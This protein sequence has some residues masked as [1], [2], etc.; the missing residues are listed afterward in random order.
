MTS[1]LAQKFEIPDWT[2]VRQV[3]ASHAIDDL[4]IN[5]Y[6][7]KTF[8]I[9]SC[10]PGIAKQLE[11]TVTQYLGTQAELIDC[12]IFENK[13]WQ[14]AKI[15][16]DGYEPS[17]TNSTEVALNLPLLNP[18]GAFMMWYG[19]EY[20]LIRNVNKE[21][22]VEYLEVAWLSMPKELYR[23]EILCPTLVKVDIPHRVTNLKATPRVMLSARFSP[24]L[25]FSDAETTTTSTS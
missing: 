25:K 22:G 12:L 4:N 14:E 8:D 13:P 3:L 19:G 10:T 15:H 24:G 9:K 20:K 21:T 2:N 1:L 5:R 17:R 7:V 6:R 16:V 23:T 18:E 11:K